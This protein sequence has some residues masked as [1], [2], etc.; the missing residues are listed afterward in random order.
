MNYYDLTNPQKAIWQVEEFYKGTDINNICG[1][2]TIKQK[3]DLDKF[4][5]AINI[6]VQNN[7]SFGLNFKEENGKVVQYFTM[8]EHQDYER[9]TLKDEEEVHNAG[10]QLSKQVLD[11]YGKQLY[12]FI[13]FSLKNGHGGFIV[14]AH[15]IISDAGTLSLIV[16]E[17]ID[18]YKKLLNNEKIVKTY[19][20]YE[21]YILDEKE[22]MNSAKF[23][24]DEEY[25]NTL[26][27]TVP[28]VASIPSMKLKSHK[29][30]TGEAKRKEF[31]LE[32]NLLN[33]I[34]DF[35]KRN[36]ISN[37]NFFMAIYS[38]YLSKVSNLK[39]FVIGT[40]ILNRTNFKEKTTTGMF[41]NTAPLRITLSDNIDFVTFAKQIAQSSLSMLRYQK[42]PYEMLLQNL[43]KKESSIPTLF[44]IILSYQVTKAHNANSNIPHEIEWFGNSTISNGMSIHFHDNNDDE[45]LNISYDYQIQKYDEK[46]I[47]NMHKRILY[48]IK[49]V[50]ENENILESDIEIITEEEKNK[51][52]YE[53]NNTKADYPKNKTI[54]QLFEEQ[55]KK[56]PNNIALV[57]DDKKLTYKE[58]NER[59]NALALY[60][61]K[62]NVKH[63]DI[64]CMLFDKSLEMI[65]SILSVLKLSAS[66][67]PI[68]I[69]YPKDRIDYI[70]NDS[71]S[72]IVLTT[73][74]ITAPLPS[75][76]STLYVDLDNAEIYDN[77]LSFVSN[78]TFSP[79]DIAYIMYTSGSTGKPKGVMVKNINVVRLVKNT[80]FIKFSEHERILQT[81]SIVFDAC[82]F[83]I[84]SA[85]LNGFE[86]YIIKKLELLDVS[87]FESY[88]AKNKITIL[89]LTAPLFNQ[90]CES[91]PAMFKDVKYLLTG[92]DV[93]S[94]KH[95]N[96]VRNSC[97]SLTIINGYGPTENTTFSTCF[98]IDKTYENTIPIGKPIAN[99]TAYVVSSSGSILPIGFAGELWV[100]GD[101]VSSGYFNNPD[102]TN[103]KFIKNPFG[104]GMIYKTGDLVKWLPDG[105]IDFI[106]RIDNQVKIRGFRVELNEI[107]NVLSNFNNIK[108]CTTIIRDVQ[109]RKTICSY[110]TSKDGV[111]ISDKQIKSYLKESLPNY[112]IP[113][114][115]C[116]LD[117]MPLTV[118]GKIDKKRLPEVI[119]ENESKTVFPINETQEKLLEVFKSILSSEKISLTDSFFELGGDSLL[120]IK[121]ILLINEKLKVRITMQNLYENSTIIELANLILSMTPLQKD[122]D[123][124]TKA[125]EKEFYHLSSA[126]KRIYYSSKIAGENTLL[127]NVPG[128]IIFDAKPDIT[129]LN[130]CFEKLIERHSSLRTYF[131]EID[132]E[133]YQKVMPNLSFKLDEIIE[134][135]KSIDEIMKDFVRPFDLAK[136]PL[137]RASFV[138]QNN[139]YMLLFD[140]HH[141][142]CDGASLDIFTNELS[143]LYNGENLSSL[144]FD[145]IDYAEW[146]FK[147]L[148]NNK[149]NHQ[150][151]FWLSEFKNLPI[152]DFPTDY[153]RPSVQSFE[154][155]K[156]YKTI[157]KSLAEKINN[158]VKKLD[159]STYMLLLSIYYVLLYKYTNCQDI[160]VG[161]PTLGRDKEELLNLM[162]MFVNTLPLKNHID[163]DLPFKDFLNN[164]KNNCIKAFDNNLYPFDKLVNDLNIP[165][166]T[167]KSPLFDTMFIYQNNGLA[168]VSFDNIPSHTYLPDTS[169]S[170]FDFSLE[171]VPKDNG[172][173]DLNF[174]YCTKLLK[175]ITAENFVSHFINIIK[176]VTENCEEK[177]ANI[178]ILSKEEKN[179]ILYEFNDTKMDFPKDKTIIELFEKQV[180]MTPNNIAIVF[181]NKK[182][183]YKELNEK[184]NSLAWY[185][186]NCGLKRNDIVSIMVNRS[187]ELLVSIIGVL[188]SGAC[189][190][191]IDPN[192]PKDR[193]EYMLE[194]SNS[195]LLLTSSSLYDTVNFVNKVVIDL[196]DDYFTG[197]I[198]NLPNINKPDDN[199]YIIYTSGSTGMPKGVVLKQISLTNLAYFLND[200]VCFFK[201]NS[202]ISIASVTTASFDIFIFETLIAL[203]K[204]LKVVIANEEEQRLPNK[205]NLLIKNNNIKAIQM[206][207]SRMKIFLDNIQ[208]CPNLSNLDYVVLAGEPLPDNLL[209]SLLSL[210]IKKVFNGFGPSETTVFSSFTDVTDYNTVNIG[211]PL[212]NTQMYILDENLSPV[213]IGIPGELYIAGYGVGN[214]YLNNE[215]ITKE[216]FIPNPFIKNSIMYKTGDLCKYLD[217]G[218]IAYIERLDNQV[219]I[220]GLRIELEEIEKKLLEVPSIKKAKVIKQT[221]KNR[222]IISAYYV[223]EKYLKS[224]EIRKFLSVYLP[225]YML[226]S[227]YTKLNDFPYTPNGKIDKNALPLP[228]VSLDINFAEYVAPRNN[229]EASLVK[230][231]E[232]IFNLSH[233]SMLDNFYTLGG[234]SLAT[235]TLCTNVR[236]SLNRDISFRDVM[237]NPII[238][239]LA[240]VIENVPI[241]NSD[242]LSIHPCQKA[243]FYPTSSAQKRMYLSSRMDEESTLYNIYG[244][245][246][247]DKMPDINKLQ[248]ALNMIVSRH[249]TLRTYF[250]II[251]GQIVQKI[252]DNLDAKIIVQDVNTN[253]PNELFYIYQSSFNLGQAPLFNLILFNLPNG[254]VLLMLDVHHIIFDGKSLNNFIDELSNIYN[255]EDLPK[256]DIS[257]K[258]FAVWENN[259]LMQNG[260]KESK[261][262]WRKEFT[263]NI[264]V[265]D[266]I[267]PNSRP[268]KKSYEGKTYV[269]F[270][271]E[272]LTEK[273]NNFA[274]TNNFTPY[275][276]MLACYYILLYNYTGQEDIIVGTPISGR[277]HKELEPL[278]GMFVNSIPLRNTCNP[279]IAFKEFLENVKKSC[280]NAFAHGDYPFDILVN[281]LKIK[282]NASRNPLFD[283]MFTYQSNGLEEVSFGEIKATYVLPSPCK[284]KFDISLEV[285]PK[286]NKLQ[287]SFEYCTELF[288]EIFVLNFAK[289]YEKILSFILDNYDALIINIPVFESKKA[290]NVVYKFNEIKLD[291]TENA[292]NINLFTKEITTTQKNDI[293]LQVASVF[294]S[295]LPISNIGIDDNFFD[296]GGDSL[297]AVNLQI[298]L[299]KSNY[300]LTYADIFECPTIRTLSEKIYS[301]EKI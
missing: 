111:N 68:D 101:G 290:N 244:G 91:N 187:L 108:E 238:E 168:S 230:I 198:H 155:A 179:K 167:S 73:K 232:N 176:K 158:L 89:W 38:I 25:W 87:L 77:T 40:P 182:L 42:Y 202:Y 110:F 145:Y 23:L 17:V 250:E 185:L 146:E 170:K 199:S 274:N 97:P 48:I 247:L 284:S 254:K 88:L 296:L 279:N 257:Y 229:V 264:P 83:E 248:N 270:L 8:P 239:D 27:S 210:G 157:N 144:S 161:T 1:T 280:V 141:I 147:M 131:E 43:R 55:S 277:F 2:L 35:C 183:T 221:I 57:F 138:T 44:D 233:I 293:E 100:G 137:F 49:Q 102:L 103:E 115:I 269:M 135:D 148:A 85:L 271:S 29:D 7:K 63:G 149:Y 120:A 282:K 243:D 22:Y 140:I 151:E 299:L 121:L 107:N 260:F 9:I 245:I 186:R 262:F 205:L 178:D 117:K 99:S 125:E 36:N 15:H 209:K 129:K 62:Q 127:Y 253:D 207:P 39:D 228:D 266:L 283:T 119:L 104:D 275:M 105:N 206:T 223:G 169:I 289:S 171:V 225:N 227:Y 281:D 278:L 133:I 3:I 94:P 222:D 255:G 54:I 154:G 193:I 46:D 21:D 285:L 213:P 273:L 5:E 71:H 139:K 219:K 4:N 256:L 298:E 34:S 69:T 92:G 156:I 14:L 236:Q 218:E 24:K 72:K 172:E 196:T 6:F 19:Y 175:K 164:V 160:V 234:D 200:Y 30:L 90:L 212:A 258:D 16:S 184:A 74:G 118:N 79:N 177:I 263:G 20:S 292:E 18:I 60:L 192:Y 241:A 82:T 301:N 165:R 252:L 194:N 211:R 95:I 70:I 80:N 150:K 134:K 112:M 116:Q 52:L 51:I 286:S 78:D 235:I 152:L 287:L 76:I 195:K 41:I 123:G 181:E 249:E 291:D 201:D 268:N 216:R 28:E 174:E 132:G 143:S 81:G 251:N 246:L 288:D 56:T 47:D 217:N 13:L 295:L 136:A 66:Y 188:K 259:Q 190:V 26:Y 11:I 159:C 276:I 130:K 267:F 180:E 106:G 189:Y 10:I 98:T 75:S 128:C 109:N 215:E 59:A 163:A 240:T 58:L 45:I 96:M 191:P 197:N 50:L 122:T 153:I 84:W 114:Y 37:F 242:T 294:K 224:N 300:K 204:G 61:K 12:K 33:Q 93:L 220:R 67:L 214:G 113:T 208:D 64:V 265:L 53:F 173:F 162:G 126:Q 237:Q 203:Q 226:P 31:L 272:A 32:K 231:L 261:E 86:L 124:I 166:D 65:I 297:M 142:I